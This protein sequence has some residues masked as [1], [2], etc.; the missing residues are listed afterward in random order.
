MNAIKK[1]GIIFSL[2]GASFIANAQNNS[3]VHVYPGYAANNTAE[4]VEF[5][6]IKKSYLDQVQR[7][8]SVEALQ[9]SNGLTKDQIRH[10]FG[11]PHFSEGLV[12]VYT[13]NYV[14]ALR[15][16]GTQDY[17]ICQL[18]IDFDKQGGEYI[19]KKHYWKGQNCPAL[20]VP[21][22][23]TQTVVKEVPVERPVLPE[24]KQHVNVVFNF[25]RF[26]EGNIVGGVNDVRLLAN[27]ILADQPMIVY[28]AGYA[29]RFGNASYNKTLSEKRAVTVSRLLQRY[30]IDSSKIKMGGLGSTE[31]FK[32]C[33]GTKKS[34]A[35]LK[36]LEE[37]RRVEVKW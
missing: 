30:G 27:Q 6:E 10:I 14:L 32:R 35:L 17:K 37:N 15:K 12:N 19:A 7:Y 4:A 11:N 21:Q 9:M 1:I 29:D 33:E 31:Q 20:D 28:V 24:P 5:P 2:L 36:C 16:P 8:E 26:D 13:W 22:V 3:S 18:R 25:D 34:P 23:I